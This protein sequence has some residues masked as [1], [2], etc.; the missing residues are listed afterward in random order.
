MGVILYA[1]RV[2]TPPLPPFFED[3]VG[4]LFL[5]HVGVYNPA[6]EYPNRAGQILP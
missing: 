3:G 1:Y 5:D 6:R 4:F 2:L